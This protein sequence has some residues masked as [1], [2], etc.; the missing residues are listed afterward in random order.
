MG[1]GLLWPSLSI[2]CRSRR[3]TAWAAACSRGALLSAASP[4][5]SVVPSGS[6]DAAL[7]SVAFLGSA[8]AVVWVLRSTRASAWVPSGSA[9]PPSAP[10][11]PFSAVLL[12]CLSLICRFLRHR[13]V[14]CF[15]HSCLLRIRPLHRLA[16]ARR[17]SLLLCTTPPWYASSAS[18]QQR[19]LC[20]IRGVL[21]SSA[22]AGAG[23]PYHRPSLRPARWTRIGARRRCSGRSLPGCGRGRQGGCAADLTPAPAAGMPTSRM[24]LAPRAPTHWWTT[25]PSHSLLSFLLA[26]PAIPA[27]IC[28]FWPAS[29]Q[30]AD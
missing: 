2:Q 4:A 25:A 9:G 6:V 30:L 15:V 21:T 12:R 14:L 3:R 29:Q 24:A 27:R 18:G 1:P 22:A 19:H 26:Y 13:V 28:R 7:A 11:P 16:L 23:R 17:S 10:S 20:R 8:A 5:S